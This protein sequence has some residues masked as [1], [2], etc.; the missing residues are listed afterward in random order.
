M[1]TIGV[2]PARY[3]S[4]RLPGKPLMEIQGKPMICGDEPLIHSEVIKK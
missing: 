2:I 3:E 1:E 4:G